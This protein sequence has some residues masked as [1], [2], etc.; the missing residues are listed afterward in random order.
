MTVTSTTIVYI[1][2]WL[3]WVLI[4]LPAFQNELG[5]DGTGALAGFESSIWCFICTSQV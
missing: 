2:A 3:G 1:L 5:K 4:G